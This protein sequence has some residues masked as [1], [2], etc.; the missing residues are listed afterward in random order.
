MFNY[1]KLSGKIRE[2]GFTQADFAKKIGIS[3]T[4]FSLKLSNRT[5]FDQREI[6]KACE[7]LSLKV[8][9]IGAYFFTK[10]VQKS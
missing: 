5:F 2:C 4:T 6:E 9:E 1:S 8:D 7:I 10:E 3:P